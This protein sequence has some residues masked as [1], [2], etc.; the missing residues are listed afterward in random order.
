MEDEFDCSVIITTI[1]RPSIRETLASIKA[2]HIRVK[3]IIVVVENRA[4]SHIKNELLN[5][6]IKIVV[7]KT[8]G[9]AAGRNLG[10]R[11]A[12][13]RWLIF[14]DDDDEFLDFAFLSFKQFSDRGEGSEQT[15]P[16]LGVFQG[17]LV[18]GR[19]IEL[20][21]ESDIDQNRLTKLLLPLS[22]RSMKVGFFIGAI[23]VEREVFSTIKFP[24][25][26]T[27]KE[28]FAWILLCHSNNVVIRFEKGA[29]VQVNR[30]QIKSVNSETIVVLAKFLKFLRSI[31]WSYSLRYLFGIGLRIQLSRI[32]FLWQR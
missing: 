19:N 2:Q 25:E 32:V 13:S 1:G 29:V 26:L 4:Y 5:E 22:L 20:K 9:A 16:W 6:E 12:H 24:E 8:G 10:A 7:N 30:D 3:E 21:Y 17:F 28:D 27:V 23:I 18:K 14:I 31:N 15:H 11:I